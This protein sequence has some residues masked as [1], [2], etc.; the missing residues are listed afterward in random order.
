M[1]T[2]TTIEILKD[3]LPTWKKWCHAKSMTSSG[4]MSELIRQVH[5]KLQNRL[6]L[7][8]TPPVNFKKPLSNCKIDKKK[9]TIEKTMSTL[10]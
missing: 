8:L 4:L 1:K 9:I 2:K 5:L 10:T 3:D 7:S 6:Y